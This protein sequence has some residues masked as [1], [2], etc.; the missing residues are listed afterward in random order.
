M[1]KPLRLG[2]DIVARKSE[3]GEPERQTIDNNRSIFARLGFQSAD[4]VSWNLQ[5]CPT[6]ATLGAMARDAYLHLFIVC[7]R[8]RYKQTH[9]RTR[10]GET[11]GIEALTGARAAKG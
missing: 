11:T 8:R 1:T 9:R 7:G 3:I 10:L 6:F 4:E 2:G 5:R